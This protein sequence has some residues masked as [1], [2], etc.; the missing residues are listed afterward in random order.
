V[1]A[2]PKPVT[3]Y[4][5][6]FLAWL[7]TQPCAVCRR[8]HLTQ[9]GLSDPAHLPRTRKWGDVENAAPLCRFHHDEFHAMGRESFARLHRLDLAAL[10]AEW[11]R[12][13]VETLHGEALAWSV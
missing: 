1:I 10:A 13:W 8:E 11:Y 6:A 4:D 7:P 12:R 3:R 9:V 5:P 2:A